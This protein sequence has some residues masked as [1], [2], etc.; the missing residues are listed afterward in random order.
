MV[1]DHFHYHQ[2]FVSDDRSFAAA[3][4]VG[5]IPSPVVM[6]GHH[7]SVVSIGADLED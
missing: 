5:A 1:A 2:I 3:M 7:S 4:I 6:P